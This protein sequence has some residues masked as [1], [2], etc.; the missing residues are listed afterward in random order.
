MKRKISMATLLAG[1]LGTA[2]LGPVHAQEGKSLSDTVARTVATQQETQKKQEA[3]AEEKNDL[4]ARYRAAMAQVDY[5]DKT[6]AFE[7]KE[8]N[9][10]DASIAELN[11]RMVESVKLKDNLEDT[12]NVV[13]DHLENRVNKD[14]PFL[15]NERRERIASVREAIAKPELSAAEKLRRVLEALQVEANYG[16]TVDVSQERIK[17]GDEEISADII[18]IGRVSVFWRSPDGNRV[19]EFDR[20]T[21]QWVEMDRKYAHVVSDVREM[22]MRLRS[23][24]VVTLPLGRI[25]P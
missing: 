17:V 19:G 25:E 5:L 4:T 14:I 24:K 7:Q 15:M 10:L 6:R 2:A 20:G 18:R 12:L 11:R 9:S 3:W 13:V 16:N 23:T 1:L 22:V 21:G 8:V